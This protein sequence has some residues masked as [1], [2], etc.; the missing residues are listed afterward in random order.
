MQEFEYLKLYEVLSN[1]E[2]KE[3]R[4]KVATLA[5]FIIHSNQTHKTK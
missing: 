4:N 1:L 2:D 5:E 3:L